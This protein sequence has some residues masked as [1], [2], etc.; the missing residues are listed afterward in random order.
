MKITKIQRQKNNPQR[1]NI[2]A[3]GVFFTGMGEEEIVRL[4]LKEGDIIDK[5][6][7]LSGIREDEFLRALNKAGEYIG[8]GL[9]TQKQAEDYLAKKGFGE[10][11]I[12]RVMERLKEYRY[13]DDDEY[14]RAYIQQNAVKGGQAIRY[15]LMRRGVS[16][17]IIDKTL[18]ER[19]ENAEMEGALKAGRAYLKGRSFKDERDARAKLFQALARRGFDYDIV[20]QAAESLLEE[21]GEF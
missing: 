18:S 13:I 15:S 4:G 17:E 21:E 5:S 6:V 9:K 2:Y 20:S 12:L 3:D 14:A 10:E 1:F 8:G 16:K 11:I 19:D 7:L